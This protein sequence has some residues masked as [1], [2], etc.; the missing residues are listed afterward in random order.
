MDL[1]EI[2]AFGVAFRIDPKSGKTGSVRKIG[3]RGFKAPEML[4]GKEYG[5]SIDWWNYGIILYVM[6][7]GQHPFHKKGGWKGLFGRNE[8]KNA[9]NQ[10]VRYPKSMPTEG[11]DLIS[12]LLVRDPAKRLGVRL[13]T[14]DELAIIAE[15]KRKQK[16]RE[17]EREKRKEEGKLKDGDDD[18]SDNGKEKENKEKDKDKDSKEKEKERKKKKK[19][20]QRF[21]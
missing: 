8:D 19:Q 3:A 6:M 9:L 14:D 20:I 1:D 12:K 21:S 2:L 18:D 7:T 17:K 15:G 11:Q 5:Y 13:P 4:T 16:E 10:E